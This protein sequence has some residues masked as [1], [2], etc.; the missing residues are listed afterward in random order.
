MIRGAS[1]RPLLVSLALL[2][3]AGCGSSDLPKLEGYIAEVN[4]RTPKPIEPLPPFEPIEMFAYEPADR[5]SP[6]VGERAEEIEVKEP[7]GLAPDPSRRKEELERFPLDSLR[8][9]GTLR[10]E[11][12][13]WALIVSKDGIL[14]RVSVGNYLGQNNG[15]VTDISEDEIQLTEIVP[16]GLGDWKERRSAIA[17]EALER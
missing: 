11:D 1:A 9:V 2:L 5:R 7:S 6:F 10:Q 8:M 4:A 15:Q 13:L 17:L 14:H 12:G 3:L 16:D